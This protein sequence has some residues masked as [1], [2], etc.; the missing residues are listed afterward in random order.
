M[1]ILALTNNA[2]ITRF[3]ILW[4]VSYFPFTKFSQLTN[5]FNRFVFTSAINWLDAKKENLWRKDLSIFFFFRFF[6]IFMLILALT[7]HIRIVRFIVLYGLS[8][9]F[10]SHSFLS[11]QTVSTNSVLFLQLTFFVVCLAWSTD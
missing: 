9:I 8:Y 2:R 10:L 7:S 1:L 4:I 5:S 6:I 3:I 11:S